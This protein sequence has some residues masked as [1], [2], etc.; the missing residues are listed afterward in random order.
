MICLFNLA[1]KNCYQGFW[2]IS[3]V[4]KAEK[5][6]RE[7]NSDGDKARNEVVAPQS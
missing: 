2:L 4:K 5:V 6:H 3:L 7:Q 1:A